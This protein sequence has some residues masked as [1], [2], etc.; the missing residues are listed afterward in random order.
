MKKRSPRPRPVPGNP[1][2]TGRSKMRR[3]AGGTPARSSQRKKLEETLK[4]HESQLAADLDATRTLQ[5][6]STKLI[7][8]GDLGS[9]LEEILGA[10][11]AVAGADFGN[12]Q[13][14][15]P[16]LGALKLAAHRGFMRPSPRSS[17]SCPTAGA[18]RAA[19]RWS[20]AS[21]LSWRT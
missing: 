17:T 20:G 6:V 7:R 5:A 21:A 3:P 4:A 19:R 2:T 1:P 11:L 15:D 9:L 8:E 12:I 13:L 18:P 10:A 16:S 14:L